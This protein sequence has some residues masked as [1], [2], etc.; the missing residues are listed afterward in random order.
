MVNEM[1]GKQGRGY[2]GLSCCEKHHICSHAFP[3]QS[4]ILPSLLEAQID[5]PAPSARHSPHMSGFGLARERD[6]GYSGSFTAARQFAHLTAKAHVTDL[7]QERKE[8]EWG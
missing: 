4:G 1:R 5:S 8:E 2:R 3:M 6:S 7:S